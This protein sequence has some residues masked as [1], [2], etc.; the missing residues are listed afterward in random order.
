V[1][2]LWIASRYVA[3]SD[4]M[5]EASSP[6]YSCA[7][8]RPRLVGVD[9]LVPFHVGSSSAFWTKTKSR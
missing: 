8:V 1:L 4:L 2:V 6:D 9:R 3:V 7:A 5:A